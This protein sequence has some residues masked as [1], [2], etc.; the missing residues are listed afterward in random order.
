LLYDARGSDHA[1]LRGCGLH[2]FQTGFM[3]MTVAHA[4]R[5]WRDSAGKGLPA[6]VYAIGLT[7]RSSSFRGQ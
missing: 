1:I 2:L 5:S 6:V 4:A 3:S 7:P